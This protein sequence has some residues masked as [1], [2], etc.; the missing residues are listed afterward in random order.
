MLRFRD[1]KVIR[2]RAFREPDEA[3]ARVGLLE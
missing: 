2:F 1:R 3:L